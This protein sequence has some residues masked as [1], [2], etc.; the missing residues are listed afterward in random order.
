MNDKGQI[1][2]G[3]IVMSAVAILIGLA[4]YTGTVSP[5]IGQMT[6]LSNS[7]NQTMT[8]PANGETSELTMCG[9]R[10][11]S[12]IITNATSGAIV[13]TTNYT[14][15]QG[16]GTDG[17]LAAKITTTTSPYAQKSVNVSC[18]YEPKGYIPESGSRGIVSLIAIFS[19]FLIVIAAFPNIRDKIFGDIIG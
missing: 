15:S 9:Q 2:F 7:Y 18:E 5:S 1:G 19:A 8:L 11:V 14:I 13:P 10:A 17:Y 16:I 12:Y 3:M 6:K 4:F